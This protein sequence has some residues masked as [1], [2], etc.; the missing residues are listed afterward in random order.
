MNQN[1]A[2]ITYSIYRKIEIQ[3][4]ALAL[5]RLRLEPVEAI[6]SRLRALQSRS[7]Q[8]KYNLDQLSRLGLDKIFI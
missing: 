6:K 3:I 2:I 5:I 4:L 1:K 8:I 7:E